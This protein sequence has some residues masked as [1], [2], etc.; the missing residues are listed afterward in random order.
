MKWI[1]RNI[2]SS[3]FS[4]KKVPRGI[5]IAFALSYAILSIVIVSLAFESELYRSIASQIQIT[6]GGLIQTTLLNYIPYFVIILLGILFKTG[7]L[8]PADVGL[9]P[10]D[11]IP[12]L[13]TITSF[14]ISLQLIVVLVSIVTGSSIDL[15]HQ[16]SSI[17]VLPVI[18]AFIAQLM[19][20]AL[21]EEIAFRGFLFPQILMRLVTRENRVSVKNV[22]F[23]III[24]QVGF[25]LVHIPVR[26]YNDITGLS[27]V[28]DLIGTMIVGIFFCIL[29][30]R[31]KNLLVCVGIHTFING[32]VLLFEP[33]IDEMI[34]VGLLAIIVTLFW[35]NLPWCR[36]TISDNS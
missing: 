4:G 12:A 17:G 7:K 5:L 33:P 24:S 10:Q 27:L 6:T 32:A 2:A 9:R 35:S 34:P 36:M 11:V 13:L 14:W 15:H 16:W 21:F 26:L 1:D 30:L 8:I 23:A 31:T 20:N 19:G 28:F 29:Y 22:I 3:I 25:A 18:G